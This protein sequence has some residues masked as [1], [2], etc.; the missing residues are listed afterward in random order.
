MTRKT[1][2]SCFIIITFSL[3]FVIPAFAADWYYYDANMNSLEG[4]IERNNYNNADERFKFK[5]SDGT[6][7]ENKWIYVRTTLDD[8]TDYQ[9]WWYYL[10]NDGFNAKGWFEIN[11]KWYCADDDTEIEL[12]GA[13]YKNSIIGDYYVGN[14]CAMVKNKWFN[15]ENAWYYADSSGKILKNTVTPDGYTGAT[16][17]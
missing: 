1:I 9:N 8:G 7:A 14:D 4:N 15:Y 17:C 11:G 6:Y 16:C 13:V 2:A 12:Y 10:K 3:M 5:M